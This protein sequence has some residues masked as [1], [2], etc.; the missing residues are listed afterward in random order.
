MKIV[1]F[2]EKLG[3]SDQINDEP[4]HLFLQFYID[5]I[6]VRQKEIEECLRKNVENPHISKIYLFGERDYKPKEL[7]VNSEKIIQIN[8][9]KRLQYMD[10]F[11]YI[12][13]NNIKGYNILANSDIF[14]DES[15][16]A[17]KY[18]QLHTQKSM[19]ALL[20]Y[21]YNTKNISS[22]PIFGPRYDSQDSWIFHSNY[23]VSPENEKIFN[24]NLGKPGCDNKM[25]YLMNI[26]GYNIINDP[27]AI[28][29]YHFHSSNIRNYTQ[30]DIIK[31]P[32]GVV[33]PH[34]FSK[35]RMTNALGINLM[36]M[37]DLR[38]SDHDFL[39]HYVKNK[40][41][42]NTNFIIPRISTI[43]T[44]FACYGKMMKYSTDQKAINNITEHLQGNPSKVLKNNAGILITNRHSI[45]KYSDMYLKAFENCEIYGGW[46]KQGHV[47]PCVAGAQDYIETQVCK[48][49]KMIW[50]FAF[51][52]FHYIQ[53]LP[54]T[55][56]LRG[57][58]ILIVS[59]FEESV[60]EKI[61]IREKIY[62]IDLFPE[63]TFITIKPPQT[64]GNESSQ[65][66][67]IEYDNFIRRLDVLKGKYDIA[68]VSCGGYGSLVTNYIYETGIPAI[69]V[70]G[71]LQMY[72]GILG[73]RWL[74]ERPDIV[75][76][77]L[78]ENWSRPK[79]LEKPENYSNIEGSCYW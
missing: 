8:I 12:N 33:V 44:E 69:Y 34:G 71:V 77:Y 20:R 17:L 78:N 14:F 76:L 32:W 67:H 63:C 1:N 36:T 9:G 47:Y 29:S 79:E 65:E 39:Y 56:A 3:V 62:G 2:S 54:W 21:E 72:F 43:E 45:Y 35:N 26:L 15:I 68:L 75:R 5:K 7:G 30:Q 25:I 11:R 61:P 46:D 13:Q 73:A 50:G 16:L 24:F 27:I 53:T 19:I 6:K 37:D 41:E 51:D 58:R 66:F 38:F 57:K 42:T 59:A 22:S 60:K 70:G 48:D 10:F 28:K 49:K 74:R 31:M 64:Q 18:S 55:H 23:N 52:I 40:L 4:I